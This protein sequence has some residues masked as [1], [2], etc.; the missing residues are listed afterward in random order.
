MRRRNLALWTRATVGV[1]CAVLGPAL[2]A[3]EVLAGG[4]LTV[5]YSFTFPLSALGG[6]LLGF[7]FARRRGYTDFLPHF[8]VTTLAGTVSVVS[9][10]GV[11]GILLDGVGITTLA[12]NATP[13]AAGL[14]FVVALF[15]ETGAMLWE[16]L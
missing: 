7:E 1:G 16:P 9:N 6:V 15:A 8:G 11:V 4:G 14:A 3:R 2:T 10:A 12:L 5:F 13:I